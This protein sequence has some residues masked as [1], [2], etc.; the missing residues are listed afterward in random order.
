VLTG[1]YAVLSGAPAIVVAVDRY[2]VADA[3][4]PAQ[5]PAP[6]EVAAAFGSDPAPELDLTSLQAEDG[7][8]LGLGSSAAA[9]VAALGARALAR[10]SDLTDPK[11][12]GDLFRTAR[13]AH[14]RVQA[15][16]SGVD[17]AASTYGGMLRYQLVGSS[18]EIR[19]IVVPPDVTLHAFASSRSARTSDLRARVDAAARENPGAGEAIG[20]A[21]AAV[22]AQAADAIAAGEASSFVAAVRAYERCLDRLGAFAGAPIVPDGWGGLAQ[23]AVSEG[24]AFIPSG[25]GG[26]DVAAWLGPTAPSPSFLAHAATLGLSP[27]RL[28][29]D[30][31]GVLADNDL[32]V[33]KAPPAPMA[34]G[35]LTS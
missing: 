15:G 27:L 6:A 34:A 5:G 35:A 9:V 31:G 14:A 28:G 21:M 23:R 18:A 33:R 8:K 29:I 10:G 20:D 32:S 2:A 17:V 30:P 12:R 26:G 25:A 13:E 3:S 1:A 16:G 19:R 24:A 11:T 4:R 7:R 22:A